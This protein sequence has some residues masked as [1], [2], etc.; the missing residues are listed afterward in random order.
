M[1]QV[2]QDVYTTKFMQE[3]MTAHEKVSLPQVSEKHF[4]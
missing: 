4:A 2:I 3:E 1:Q